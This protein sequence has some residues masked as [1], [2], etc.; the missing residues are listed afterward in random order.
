MR[1]LDSGLTGLES[2]GVEGFR[3]VRVQGFRGL[4]L[5]YS[6][7]YSSFFVDQNLCNRI[8]TINWLTKER[9]YN[10]DYRQGRAA[11]SKGCVFVPGRQDYPKAPCTF[12][13]YT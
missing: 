8:L 9:N 11:G 13:V 1:S 5:T 12:I 3:S 4:G 2:F 6:L 10:G 7:H